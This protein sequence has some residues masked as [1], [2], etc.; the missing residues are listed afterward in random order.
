M[1][2]ENVEEFYEP[3]TQAFKYA[4]ISLRSLNDKLADTGLAID[5]YVQFS[6]PGEGYAFPKLI[7]FITK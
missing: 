5:Q 1:Y 3:S 4:K 7:P 2:I 6:C